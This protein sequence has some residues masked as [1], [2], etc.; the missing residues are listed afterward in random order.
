MK[1]NSKKTYAM[2]LF[3]IYV[4]LLMWIIVFKFQFSIN[5]LDRVRSLNLIPFKGALILNGEIDFTE[6][7][8]NVFIFIPFGIYLSVLEFPELFYK[9]VI[10]ILGTSFIF[11]LLQ[12]V[13]M[14]GRSDISD[15]IENTLGG[16]SGIVVYQALL[17]LLSSKK[18]TNKFFISCASVFTVLIL[19]L[20]CVIFMNN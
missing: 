8:Q 11:E 1:S 9:K 6:I 10:V 4:L 5:S 12:F 7:V 3:V 13:L 20:F 2:L 18:K 14:I 19:I 15:I 16:F 17:K